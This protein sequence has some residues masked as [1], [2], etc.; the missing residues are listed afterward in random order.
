ML[1]HFG[2]SLSEVLASESWLIDNVEHDSETGD[3]SEALR[4]NIL[5]IVS[6][7]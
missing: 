5:A 3:T 2:A 6:E 4:L 1:K 7:I